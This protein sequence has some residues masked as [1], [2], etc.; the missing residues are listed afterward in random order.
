M[1]RCSAS[2]ERLPAS[3]KESFGEGLVRDLKYEPLPNHVLWC[4]GRYGAR[5][6]LFGPANTVVSAP[7][8]A[9]WVESILA[10]AYTSERD[11]GDAIFA[12][13]QVAGVSG[14]RV[15]DLAPDLRER[16]AQ[17]LQAMGADPHAI[18][19][20]REYQERAVRELGQALGDALPVGL[21]LR[22][23][24]EGEGE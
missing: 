16:V 14:D 21:R 7:T 24:Q 17:R 6:P 10:R 2:L 13:S 18:A 12:L 11:K 19:S 1:W 22:S 8:A 9:R 5:V 3:V 20:V 15:R 23:D 4:L